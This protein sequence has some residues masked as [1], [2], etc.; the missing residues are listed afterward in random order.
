MT[1]GT[2]TGTG[3]AV[4]ISTLFTQE[5]FRQIDIKGGS[6]NA[7]SAYIGPSTVTSAGANA[8]IELEAGATWGARA[9]AGDRLDIDLDLLYVVAASS[10]LVH[11]VVV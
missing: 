5:K 3:S 6:G 10:E 9:D 7:A 1:G 2:H 11:F 4:K 8:Y